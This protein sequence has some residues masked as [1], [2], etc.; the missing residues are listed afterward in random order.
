VGPRY[1]DLSN[2]FRTPA[3]F[4]GGRFPLWSKI[5]KQKSK[6]TDAGILTLVDRL[7]RCLLGKT[8]FHHRDHLAVAVAY[9]YSSDMEMAFARMR[10]TLIRFSTHHDVPQLYHETLT[11][12]WME[13]VEKRLDRSL[14]L[15]ESVGAIQQALADKNL[16]FACYRKETLNSPEAK[17][18]FIEPELDG[19]LP[20]IQ[21][22]TGNGD[23]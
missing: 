17:Q 8:E 21:V 15:R 11:R 20:L 3:G 12:F 6:M 16:P 2:R 19:T 10:A 13:Q 22:Q 4:S 5:V 9:L 7:E 14:C 18:R 23:T 1:H